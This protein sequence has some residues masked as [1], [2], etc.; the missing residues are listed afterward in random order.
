MEYQ[1]ITLSIPREILKK[2]K[3]LAV[4]KDTSVSGLLSRYLEEIVVRD[5]AYKRAKER[6]MEIMERGF[7]L[8][9]KGEISWNREELHERR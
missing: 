9:G 3:H 6:Q 1:N 5:D 7:D 2:V 8:L 4:E